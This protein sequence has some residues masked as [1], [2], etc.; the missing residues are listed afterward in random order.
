MVDADSTVVDVYDETPAECTQDDIDQWVEIDLT[1]NMAS[2]LDYYTY[3][4]C[5]YFGLFWQDLS[6]FF[7]DCAIADD[8]SDDYET[9]YSE[10]AAIGVAMYTDTTYLSWWNYVSYDYSNDD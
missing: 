3:T 6:D 2:G 7:S 9:D 5:T 8:C 10:G 4:F 1:T